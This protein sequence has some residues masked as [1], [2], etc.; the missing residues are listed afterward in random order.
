MY[1]RVGSFGKPTTTHHPPSGPSP[2]LPLV[3]ALLD[4]NHRPGVTLPSHVEQIIAARIAAAR[5]RIEANK[6]R[7]A[8]MAAAR[9]R[10]LAARHAAKL[11]NQNKEQP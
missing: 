8:S 9:Q 3:A 6:R 11:R 4:S 7:R 2:Q 1:V 5:A 10:G